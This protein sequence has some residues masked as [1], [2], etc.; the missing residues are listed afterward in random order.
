MAIDLQQ[1]ISGDAPCD[2][3]A[4]L[5]NQNPIESRNILPALTAEEKSEGLQN[6]LMQATDYPEHMV[7]DVYELTNLSGGSTNRS[8]WLPGRERK[9]NY[10]GHQSHCGNTVFA[11][12]CSPVCH[13]ANFVWHC[14]RT[15]K[16]SCL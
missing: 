14:A 8:K 3:N 4:S 7:L 15:T 10:M 16:T 9:P 13:I 11:L 5:E 6:V 2:F 1:T 12:G